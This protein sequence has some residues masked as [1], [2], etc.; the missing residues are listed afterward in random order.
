MKQY[1]LNL[2]SRDNVGSKFIDFN[3]FNN[4]LLFQKFDDLK[5]FEVSRNF[6][7]WWLEEMKKVK[8]ELDF[9]N[10]Y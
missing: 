2:F 4:K 10:F 7:E 9:F 8:F 5:S 6:L 1:V 3:L